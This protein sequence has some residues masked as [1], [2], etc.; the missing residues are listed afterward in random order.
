MISSPRARGLEGTRLPLPARLAA[1][2]ARK[3]VS[4]EQV[5]RSPAPSAEG[6][7]LLLPDL[8]AIGRIVTHWRYDRAGTAG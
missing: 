8:A 4:R 6:A 1:A 2:L 7:G 3:W 5:V